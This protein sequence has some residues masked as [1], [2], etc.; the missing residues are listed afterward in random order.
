ME[1]LCPNDLERL[2][3]SSVGGTAALRTFKV[4]SA[5]GIDRV[6]NLHVEVAMKTSYLTPAILYAQ[7]QTW[8]GDYSSKC[9]LTPGPLDTSTY[10]GTPLESAVESIS[11]EGFE[12]AG[13][14]NFWEDNKVKVRVHLFHLSDDP[15]EADTV[16]CPGSSSTQPTHTLTSLP[17]ADLHPL[18]ASLHMGKGSASI[19]AR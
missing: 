10:S 7:V 8:I 2:P 14:L 16:D 18:W 9:S 15:P 1:N 3:T 5:P 11:L 4:L 19:K 17:S 6:Y 12:E 13:C